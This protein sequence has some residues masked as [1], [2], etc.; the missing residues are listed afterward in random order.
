[1]RK[2]T[3]DDVERL[4]KGSK[5][6][7]DR[8]SGGMEERIRQRLFPELVPDREEMYGF[9]VSKHEKRL[10]PATAEEEDQLTMAA[11]LGKGELLKKASE[12]G[13]WMG[14]TNKFGDPGKIMIEVR[15]EFRVTGV[16]V[17][18]PP[19]KTEVHVSGDMG[20]TDVHE[21]DGARH[22]EF[23]IGDRFDSER[24]KK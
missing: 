18:G 10:R 17:S 11:G 24:T 20:T 19:M 14:D 9:Q 12:L 21:F 23:V 3:D 15:E 22:D 4:A 1:M 13:V 5:G 8:N 7:V 16:N 6:I 2:L